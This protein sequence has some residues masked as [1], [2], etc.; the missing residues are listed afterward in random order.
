MSYCIYMKYYSIKLCNLTLF[1]F[2]MNLLL[3]LRGLMDNK[4]LLGKRIRELRK[5]KG[6]KQEKLAELVGLEPTSISN[7]ENGYNYPTIQNLEKIALAL[8]SSFVDIFKFEQHN[9]TK[10]LI[11]EI[12]VML[13]KNPDKTRDFYKILKALVE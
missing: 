13:N 7:I 5:K 6:I 4:K 1:P 12:N 3:N 11:Y 8:N 2:R 9:D 10:D